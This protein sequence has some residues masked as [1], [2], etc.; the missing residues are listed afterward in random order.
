MICSNGEV[1]ASRVLTNRLA[2]LLFMVI[3]I[4]STANP[5][6]SEV[7]KMHLED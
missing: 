3:M 5:E 1:V 7:V 4:L 2:L 6:N